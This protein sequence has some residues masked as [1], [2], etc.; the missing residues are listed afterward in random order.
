MCRLIQ[1]QQCCSSLERYGSTVPSPGVWVGPRDSLDQ[2]NV[3]RCRLGMTQVRSQSRAA[4]TGASQ[5]SVE[6]LG[7]RG[8]TLGALV[9]VPVERH[10]LAALEISIILHRIKQ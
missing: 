2:Q 6:A 10:L 1:P 7:W 3:V 4:S 8:R 9:Q 5:N